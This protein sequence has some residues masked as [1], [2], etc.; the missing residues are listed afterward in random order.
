MLGRQLYQ[1]FSASGPKTGFTFLGGP[2]TGNHE[3]V[4][5][6]SGNFEIFDMLC[7]TCLSVPLN[8]LYSLLLLQCLPP[9]LFFLL[10]KYPES[11]SLSL[12]SNHFSN[13]GTY[14]PIFYSLFFRFPCRFSIHTCSSFPFFF[15]IQFYLQ[16]FLLIIFSQSLN[17]ALWLPS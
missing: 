14:F 11:I 12:F 10:T 17:H 13:T 15:S 5:S 2:Q 7:P 16:I 8:H 1:Y 4:K 9:L 6:S 3:N